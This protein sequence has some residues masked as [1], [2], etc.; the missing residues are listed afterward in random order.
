MSTATARVRPQQ[1]PR[2]ATQTPPSFRVIQGEKNPKS[3]LTVLLVM[4]SA[5]IAV[6]L[7]NLIIN[8]QMAQTAHE[9]RDM[10]RELILTT[11]ENNALLQQLQTASSPAV[12]E[13]NAVRLGMT[14]AKVAGYVSLTTQGIK[15]D[16]KDF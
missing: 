4:V 8:T 13:Q 14:P 1:Q 9:L 12:L 15:T 10:N 3:H 6:I 16:I 7:V 5:F 2:I 11:E